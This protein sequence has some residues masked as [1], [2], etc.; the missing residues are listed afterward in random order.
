M[1]QR[2]HFTDEKFKDQLFHA[3]KVLF[4]PI[5]LDQIMFGISSISF[6]QR[7]FNK[8]ILD[9]DMWDYQDVGK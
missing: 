3:N 7:I 2:A 4:V 8:N 1:K 6:Y 9:Y 5:N